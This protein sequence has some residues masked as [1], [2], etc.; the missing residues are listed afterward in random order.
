MSLDDM[1]TVGRELCRDAEACHGVGHAVFQSTRDM[2]KAMDI[3]KTISGND[4]ACFNGVAMEYADILADRNM[5]DVPGVQLPNTE[6]LASVCTTLANTT[7]QRS[8][9]RYYPR[10]AMSALQEKGYT[11]KESY[12]QVKNICQS[13]TSVLQRTACFQGIGAFNTYFVLTDQDKGVAA[14]KGL[15]GG[16]QNQAACYFGEVAV[17]VEERQKQL[18]QYCPK[19]PSIALQSNCYE[20]IFYYLEQFNVPTST[21]Q[22]LCTPE[23]T[24]CKQAFEHRDNR[25][26]DALFK[27]FPH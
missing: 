2:Q 3:C 22:A 21:A 14:C 8:C 16:T 11:R 15:P 27:D 19:L 17:A 18:I 10:M 12:Q 1:R 24:I 25:P 26:W 7:E 23:N 13:Y 4:S 9:F 20:Q 6:T 5:R